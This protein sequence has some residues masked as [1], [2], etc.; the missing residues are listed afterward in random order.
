MNRIRTFACTALL[1]SLAACQGNAPST[2]TE[3][4]ASSH[5]PDTTLGRVVNIGIEEARQK[6]AT[7][8]I[9]LNRIGVK[10]KGGGDGVTI[11]GSV[12]THDT[13]PKGEITPAGDLLIDGKAVAINEE[14]RTMLL[15]HRAHIIGIAE[16]GMEI[17]V[18]GADLAGKALGEVA[19]GL[20]NGKSEKEIE[21]G[22]EA[23]AAQI[24]ASAAKLCARLPELLASQNQLAAA[25]P[26]FQPYATMTRKDVDECMDEGEHDAA[27][28]AQVQS[29]IRENIRQEIRTGIRQGIRSAIRGTARTAAG[30][31]AAETAAGGNAKAEAQA[32][33]DAATR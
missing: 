4:S 23:E 11:F 14:Q 22:I 32:D 25:L 21:Q 8:N 29:E 12:D 27:S 17:G 33:S 5:T 30:E 3:P 31:D 2:Q 15:A 28:R 9:S 20:F 10:H 13:R 19:K 16:S 6:L 1:A 26:E 24:K 7:E 18:Q